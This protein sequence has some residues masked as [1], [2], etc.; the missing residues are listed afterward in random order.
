MNIQAL[1]PQAIKGV[2]GSIG[3]RRPVALI[4]HNLNIFASLM[5]IGVLGRIPIRISE[6][7]FPALWGVLYIGFT[8]FIT[9]RLVP[10]GEPQFVYFFMDTTLGSRVNCLI[11][12]SLIV[13]LMTFFVLFSIIDDFLLH[14]GG[15]VIFNT[16]AV[17]LLSSSCCRFRD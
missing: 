17:I 3:L 12:T 5:D 16:T 14:L 6:I 4:Q 7:S 8:W 11:L 9:H 13:V 10:S 1:W 15:G 2:N